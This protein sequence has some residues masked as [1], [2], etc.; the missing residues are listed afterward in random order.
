VG[1]ALANGQGKPEVVHQ[2]EES[3]WPTLGRAEPMA[4]GE[5]KGST[6]EP[7]DILVRRSPREESQAPPGIPHRLRHLLERLG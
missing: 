2:E 6:F 1:A 5:D 4:H 3:T 7:R